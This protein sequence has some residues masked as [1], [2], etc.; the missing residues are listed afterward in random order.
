MEMAGVAG[1]AACVRLKSWLCLWEAIS[2]ILP[3][4]NHCLSICYV[5]GTMCQTLIKAWQT[6]LDLLVCGKTCNVSGRWPASFQQ[7][8]L[9]VAA[10]REGPT[11]APDT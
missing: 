11:E 1:R 3:T 10:E 8:Q 5:P 7:L 2:C 6:E 9:G 4:D